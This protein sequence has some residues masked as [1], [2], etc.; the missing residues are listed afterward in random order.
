MSPTDRRPSPAR[1]LAT[2]I[3]LAVALALAVAACNASP[4]PSPSATLTPTGSPT[5]AS[6]PASVPPSIAPSPSAA[7]PAPPA[8]EAALDGLAELLEADDRSFHINQLASATQA[9]EE[10]EFLYELDV[11]GEDFA[12]TITIAGETFDLGHGRR[13][14]VGAGGR[15][16]VAVVAPRC[17]RHPRR[18]RYLPVHPADR[19]AGLRVGERRGR[20]ADLPVPRHRGGRVPDRFDARRGN[21]R[22]GD[23]T[24]ARDRGRWHAAPDDHGLRGRL[25]RRRRAGAH[26]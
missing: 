11:S 7:A 3:A 1:F 16:R 2:V 13:H 4:S 22:L 18:R 24:D 6:A 25:G 23:G 14:I 8:A 15:R 21:Q 26:R 9:T 19:R 10:Q 5:A 12:G 20:D 17:R